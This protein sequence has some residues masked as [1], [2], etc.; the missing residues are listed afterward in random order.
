VNFV[1]RRGTAFQ[2]LCRSFHL[3]RERRH[4]TSASYT[5][6]REAHS[7]GM[8]LLEAHLTQAQLKQYRRSGFFEVVGGDTK[9]RYR[10]YHGSQMNIL[11]IDLSGH[12]RWTLCFAPKGHLV[13]G[14]VM[15]AQKVAL[16]LF[17]TTALAIANRIPGSYRTS[18]MTWYDS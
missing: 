7:R 13:L 6:R 14:D 11:Q 2:Q 5:L 16:E 12:P 9:L 17:E 8:R 1:A 3:W 4:A 18:P 10:I 15:L